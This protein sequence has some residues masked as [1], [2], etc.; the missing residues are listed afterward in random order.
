[1]VVSTLVNT[2]KDM[3]EED[4]DTMEINICIKYLTL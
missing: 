4:V 1:M 2:D 3:V